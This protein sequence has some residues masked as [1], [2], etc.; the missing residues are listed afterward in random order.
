M[1]QMNRR[2]AFRSRWVLALVLV[3]LGPSLAAQTESPDPATLLQEMSS[4]LRALDA[5]ELRANVTFDDVPLPDTKVQYS[6]SMEVQ[7]RRPDRLRMTYQDDLT[8][9]ELWLDGSMV[10]ILGPAENLW[11]ATTAE[12]TIDETLR[13]LAADYGLAL[14]LDDLFSSDP[15]SVLMGNVKADRY[16]GLHDVN[17]VA[18]HH[19]IFGQENV[20]WQVWIEAGPKP[21]IRK[22]VITY[23]NL[24]MAPQYAV[25]V[26]GWSLNPTLPDS[27]FDPQIPGDAV[28]I[29]F[30]AVEEARP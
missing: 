1:I 24:P 11:A 22:V 14:P 30:L 15:H 4:Y 19:L 10:T 17:G 27:R 16:M 5:F 20:N 8:A 2:A 12:S 3:S 25:E 21:L 6:G 23:K 29:D 9:R 18:C 13:M 28:E 26:T 7:L